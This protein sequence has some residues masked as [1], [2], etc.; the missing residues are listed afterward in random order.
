MTYDLVT[1]AGRAWSRPCQLSIRLPGKAPRRRTP[2][3]T[4]RASVASN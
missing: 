3:A 4:V 1:D 2:A